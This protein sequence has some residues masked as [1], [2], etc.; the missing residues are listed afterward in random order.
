[1]QPRSRSRV[2]ISRTLKTDCLLVM[3][4]NQHAFG[5]GDLI[6]ILELPQSNG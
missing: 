6:G 3:R 1:M 4:K 2:G 5:M